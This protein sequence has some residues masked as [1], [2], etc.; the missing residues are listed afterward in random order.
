[1]APP[2]ALHSSMG[3]SA[4][5]GA[6]RSATRCIASQTSIPAGC[7]QTPSNSVFSGP[8]L[9]A[10]PSSLGPRLQNR[11]SAG[12]LH[13]S[14]GLVGRVHAPERPAAYDDHSQG[15]SHSNGSS[16]SNGPAPGMRVSAEE[17]AAQ[18]EKVGHTAA[19]L[20]PGHGM[21]ASSSP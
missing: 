16:N 18:E 11:L 8:G 13:D 9:A 14:A 10:A 5:S 15:G 17:L 6:Q 4:T 21:L 2:A 12:R 20:C 7:S 1:M 3:P 19:W